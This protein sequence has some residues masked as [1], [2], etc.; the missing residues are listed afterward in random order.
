MMTEP[1]SAIRGLLID[2]TV[3]LDGSY[4]DFPSVVI[5]VVDDVV[6]VAG[7]DDHLITLSIAALLKPPV[8]IV[9][10]DEAWSEW[11]ADR[12]IGI[13]FSDLWKGIGNA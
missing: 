4:G 7:P 12:G 9:P 1:G 13:K 6:V 8:I 10:T 11:Q 2:A 3:Y 5:D